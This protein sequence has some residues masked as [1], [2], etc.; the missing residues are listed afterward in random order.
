M[1]KLDKKCQLTNIFYTHHLGLTTFG[2]AAIVSKLRKLNF[3]VRGDYLCDV[4]D[5]LGAENQLPEDLMLQEFWASEQYFFHDADQMQLV[6]SSCPL[7]RKMT[8][9]FSKECVPDFMVLEPFRCLKELHLW[10]G[11]FYVDG[12]NDLLYKIGPQLQ[13]LYLVHV[14]QVSAFQNEENWYCFMFS[15]YLRLTRTFKKLML[16]D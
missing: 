6:A 10:G 3:L 2:K 14:D 4:L 11:E 7:I 16:L 12:L 9:Q 15:Q 13:V 5:Y 1:I 8:F